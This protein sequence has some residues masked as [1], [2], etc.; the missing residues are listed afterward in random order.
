[1][2]SNRTAFIANTMLLLF[3]AACVWL[4]L[5][6]VA[7]EKER[8]LAN[9]QARLGVIAESQKRTV[10]TALLKQ[11]EQLQVMADNPLVQIFLAEGMS[12][13]QQGASEEKLGQMH[14]L[15]NLMNATA[16]ASGVFTPVK[17]IN[18]NRQETVN[19]GLAITGPERILMSTRYFPAE[20]PQVIKLV[21]Q[22]L[23]KKRRIIS[24]IYLDPSN[25]P[26]YIIAV[27]VRS[28]QS[29]N[30][31]DF[32]GT[33]VAVINPEHSI[34]KTIGRH[35]LTTMSDETIIALRGRNSVLYGSPLKHP[36]TVFHRESADNDR[37]ATVFAVNH[38]GGFALKHD[39]NNN[40]VLVTS[41]PVNNT[42]WILVQKINAS[43]ALKESIS[44]QKFILVI[45]LLFVFFIAV[46]FIAIWRHATSLRLKK[47]TDR[48]AARTALLN[49]VSDSITDFIFLLDSEEKLV[50]VNRALSC[51]LNVAAADVKG[52]ALNHLYDVDTAS[53]LLKVK[54]DGVTRNREMRLEINGKRHDY[55]VT[56]VELRH[57]TYQH[58]HLYVLHDITELKD[59]QGKHNRMMEAI[60]RT[61]VRL[62]DIHDPHCAF[63][64]ER[65][66]EVA[67]AIANAMGL[68]KERVESLGMAALLA[69][70]G[71]LY[72]PAEVL[73]SVEV[74]TPES[75]AMLRKA[76]DYTVEILKDLEFEGP[77]VDIVKQ[78]NEYLDGSGYPEG[79]AG[80]AILLESRILA[81]ANAFV[82]MCSSRA[83]RKGMSMKDVL[84]R[85]FEQADSHYD[86]Q[87]LAS[88]LYV[89][90]NR[91]DWRNWQDAT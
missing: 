22:A 76:N 72:L 32:R 90:E 34:Y 49:A 14:H 84:D 4:V 55:H 82:A 48:L 41:R 37:V 28:V 25:Q 62:I 21:R 20:D 38:P 7:S 68:P 83:Y 85:L 80:D 65:T 50:L 69:N 40:E 43:E 5:V 42:S 91:A 18:N 58:S 10:D 2:K 53:R 27:P 75:S 31:H 15:K 56:V 26:R 63:H 16:K 79:I 87:V 1:M 46:S 67:I 81:V 19:D 47:T 86:R 30:N 59:T 70:V 3:I 8:D 24:D 61:L 23:S 60:I 51:F 29:V 54:Q 52:K 88:L 71:K 6:Y 9:W 77:V 74:L 12:D 64:S 17:V 73:T 45:L 89:A 35:W 66:R 57:E 33:V 13:F 39:Y 44:H 78:K 11:S 36:F